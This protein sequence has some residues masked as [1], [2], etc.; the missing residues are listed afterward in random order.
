V[1]SA[2]DVDRARAIVARLRSMYGVQVLELPGWDTR[3]ADWPRVP[4]GIIDHHDASTRKAGE[5]GA[6]GVVRDGRPDVPGP[7]ASWHGARCLDGQPRVA[8]VA[9]GRGNHAGKGGPLLGAP[10]DA[11]NPWLYGA[12]WANDGV[13]EPFTAAAHYAH[14]ALFRSVAD[15]CGFP[16]GSV[17]GHKEWAPGRKSDPTYSMAW[18]RAGVAGIEP[19]T[20]A[21]PE[22]RRDSVVQC[23]Q[24]PPG[25]GGGRIIVPTGDG[26]VVTERAWV[27]FA[28]N[29]PAAGKVRAWF[30]T[31]GGKGISDTGALRPVGFA[32]GA[33]QVVSFELPANT[34]QV[35]MQWDMPQG[36]TYTVET[37][38]RR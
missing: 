32:N 36:G 11:G 33:S 27:S 1:A 21:A 2:A 3:G 6:L 31:A 23:V 5:W 10:R 9:A 26:A 35:S 25:V 37:L 20:P 34:A 16:I 24:I 13:A 15:V 8:L 19:R 17:I 30:Q 4:V 28:V 29:G 14:D 12:E 38:A 7:L 22:R 18:R